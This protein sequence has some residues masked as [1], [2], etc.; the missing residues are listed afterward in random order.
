MPFTNKK[1]DSWTGLTGEADQMVRNIGHK[2]WVFEGV[3]GLQITSDIEKANI[4]LDDYWNN[5]K[6]SLI[7]HLTMLAL[8]EEKAK[9][10]FFAAQEQWQAY[11][12]G[13]E[14][15]LCVTGDGPESVPEKRPESYEAWSNEM[16][17]RYGIAC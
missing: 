12:N 2:F 7:A 10:L 8:D 1:T 13:I 11:E 9:E 14:D 17:T 4:W 6:T 5:P 15:F 16:E 3:R